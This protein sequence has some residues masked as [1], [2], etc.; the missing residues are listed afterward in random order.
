MAHDLNDLT[1]AF[2]AL[3]AESARKRRAREAVKNAS[4]ER[5]KTRGGKTAAP[6]EK[7]DSIEEALA[8]AE[9]EHGAS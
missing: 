2:D 6:P 7:P 8:L 1:V 3:T 4:G 5:P 9:A